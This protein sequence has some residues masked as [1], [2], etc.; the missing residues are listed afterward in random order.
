MGKLYYLI[1][2]KLQDSAYYNSA[3]ILNLY[4]LDADFTGYTEQEISIAFASLIEQNILAPHPMTGGSGRNKNYYLTEKG[5][6]AYLREKNIREGKRNAEEIQR[7]ISESMLQ[8]NRSIVETN[9]SVKQTN[10]SMREI[11]SINAVNIPKVTN[12]TRTNVALTACIILLTFASLLNTF[13][14]KNDSEVLKQ[15][16]ETNKI[17]KDQDQEFRQLIRHQNEMDSILLNRI[18]LLPRK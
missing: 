5:K 7:Q 15:L 6:G 2:D 14:H 3:S 8:V 11:N 10:E 12:M 18:E 16:I 1:L 13:F 17:L 9:E 4:T